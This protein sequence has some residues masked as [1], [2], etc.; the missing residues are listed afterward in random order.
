MSSVYRLC[1]LLAPTRD[2][3]QRYF[4]TPDLRQANQSGGSFIHRELCKNER[5][6]IVPHLQLLPVLNYNDSIQLVSV[7]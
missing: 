6:R 4:G 1:L 5:K 2:R 7:S 3:Q